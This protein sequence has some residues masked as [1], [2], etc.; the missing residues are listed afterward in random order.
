MSRSTPTETWLGARPM[1]SMV[2]SYGT[3]HGVRG[4]RVEFHESG[5]PTITGRGAAL[6]EACAD[7][8]NRLFAA[9]H[10]DDEEPARVSA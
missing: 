5:L 3:F 10:A 2:G 7:G 8:M 6:D 4:W 9:E 1:R